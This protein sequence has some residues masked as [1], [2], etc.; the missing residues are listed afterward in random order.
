[1]SSTSVIS[2]A[3]ADRKF[4]NPRRAKLSVTADAPTALIGIELCSPRLLPALSNS[5]TRA[6]ESTRFA[7]TA[8]P[9]IVSVLPTSDPTAS[10]SDTSP[11][12][13]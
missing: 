8:S 11:R 10:S 7:T 6:V 12:T 13:S 3:V 4:S 1:L 2:A 5:S 9:V